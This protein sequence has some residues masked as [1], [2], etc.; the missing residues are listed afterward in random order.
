MVLSGKKI[1]SKTTTVGIV[2]GDYVVLAADKRATAGSLVAHKRVKKIIRIDDYIAMTISGLVADAEIIAE[3]ARFI[4]R[5]YKLELGRPIKVSALASNLSI[6]LNAYLRMS[7][8]IVQLLLGGYDDNGPHLFYIDLF[9]SLSEEKYMATGS[10]SPTAF[11]VLEEEYR[12]DLSLDEAKEL[13]FKAVS[14]AT[15]RDG[16]SGEGVD[17]VVIGPNTYVEETKLFKRSIIAK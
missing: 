10:G 8:Y 3:Q 12:S 15:K 7:P 5:K 16:F 6:I 13:A 17:I 11:G 4:A 2:V 1:V 14:A 9:G